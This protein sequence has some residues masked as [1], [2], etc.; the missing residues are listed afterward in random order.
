LQEAITAQRC[1]LSSSQSGGTNQQ[2]RSDRDK[3]AQ[4]VQQRRVQLAADRTTRRKQLTKLTIQSNNAAKKL[5]ETNAL[6][7]LLHP[8]LIYTLIFFLQFSKQVLYAF[9]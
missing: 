5:Q 3:L 8:H 7:H 1:Q 4:E 6:V 9:K 2:L